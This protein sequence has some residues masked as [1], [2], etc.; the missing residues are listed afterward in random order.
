M[1]KFTCE[2]YETIKK[3]K[4]LSPDEIKK[5]M[6]IVRKELSFLIKYNIPPVPKN[7]ERWFLLFCHLN[8]TGKELTDLEIIGLY[9]EIFD[10]D[11]SEITEKEKDELSE[12]LSNIAEKLDVIMLNLIENISVH[13]RNIDNHTKKLSESTKDISL[14]DLTTAVNLVLK[15]IQELKQQ[16]MVLK[17]E[18]E[19][20]H[21]EI[22]RLQKELAHAKAEASHDF[23]TG[24]VN[25]KRFERAVEDAIKDFH[26]KNY[27]FSLIYVDIDDFKRINDTYGHLAGDMVLKEIA[28]IF[29]FYLRAN[30]VVG[31]I[32]GEEFGILL[33][34]VEIKDAKNVAER[35]R[36]IIE[37]REVKLEDGK[38]V[39]V[40]AS[41]GVTQVKMGDTVKSF[42]RR[43]DEALYKAKKNGKN[44]VEVVL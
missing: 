1:G 8:E 37:N 24:L 29:R 26:K 31:R 32:G 44:R 14:A 15:E 41:F 5:V 40:T 43:A 11:V 18:V 4:R 25:R 9:K 33:P 6:D 13:Q 7:Y 20:Y 2:F 21:E 30:T 12:T 22:K 39:R 36:R 27:P 23:L 16:N 28:S 10:E 3:K 19:R 35:L 38:A 17:N 34:G 42:L